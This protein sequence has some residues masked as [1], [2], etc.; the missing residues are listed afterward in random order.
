M[1]HYELNPD[2]KLFDIK[3][4]IRCGCFFFKISDRMAD[5]AFI[6]VKTIQSSGETKDFPI[7]FL[8][9]MGPLPMANP[10]PNTQVWARVCTKFFGSQALCLE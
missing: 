6:E 5:N 8:L 10:E 4:I 7:S 2:A 9:S 3:N 1:H